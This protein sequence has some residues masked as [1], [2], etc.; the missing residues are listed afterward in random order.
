MPNANCRD[1]CSADRKRTVASTRPYAITAALWRTTPQNHPP[2]HPLHQP[3]AP[4]FRAPPQPFQPPPPRTHNFPPPQALICKCN[5][6]RLAR[7][8]RLVIATQLQCC[9]FASVWVCVCVCRCVRVPQGVV[10]QRLQLG[11]PHLRVIN[12]FLSGLRLFYS[13]LM[14]DDADTSAPW[15]R[16]TTWSELH[17][18]GGANGSHLNS[19]HLIHIIH[20]PFPKSPE[21]KPYESHIMAD[22]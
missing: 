1:S 4:H 15:M 18:C 6:L 2:H 22:V 16:H 17:R 20:I 3:R 8:V 14:T 7:D 11:Q 9:Q 12:W 10:V 21:G 19:T 5:L 13:L